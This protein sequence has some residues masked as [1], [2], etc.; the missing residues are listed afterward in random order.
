VGGEEFLV[1][2]PDADADAR[3]AQRLRRPLAPSL[4]TV[5]P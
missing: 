2:L 5:Y 4:A 1:L 3:V